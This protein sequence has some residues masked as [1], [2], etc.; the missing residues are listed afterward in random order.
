MS[1]YR[2]ISQQYAQGGIKAAILLNGGAAIAVLS[3]AA[4]LM[5]RGLACEIRI[6]MLLWVTGASIAALIWF[7]AFMSARFV[8]KSERNP[9]KER[10]HIRTSDLYMK[11][12]Q[13]FLAASLGC[14]LVGCFVLA[15]G[16]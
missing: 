1:D 10:D 16:L 4:E 2:E 6:A 14:F 3:Q 15:W 7:F 13:Y 5:K 12:G 8:D 11:W 9:E